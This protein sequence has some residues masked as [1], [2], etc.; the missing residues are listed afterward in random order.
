MRKIR[1][2]GERLH[3]SRRRGGA[4]HGRLPEGLDDAGQRRRC[5]R[6]HLRRRCAGRSRIGVGPQGAP[7]PPGR[8]ATAGIP[9]G[10]S[11]HLRGVPDPGQKEGGGPQGQT[12]GAN[13]RPMFGSRPGPCGSSHMHRRAAAHVRVRRKGG[14]HPSQRTCPATHRAQPGWTQSRL[15]PWGSRDGT[16][17]NR[18]RRTAPRYL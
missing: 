5:F 7:A 14:T 4:S 2:H 6:H 1:K 15:T 11:R 9:R 13:A 8:D 17:H 16:A 12:P 18:A 3:G 10:P